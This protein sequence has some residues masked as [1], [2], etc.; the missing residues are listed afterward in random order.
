MTENYIS[1]SKRIKDIQIFLKKLENEN[2][3]KFLPLLEGITD[4]G[5]SLSLGF[6][7]YA[8]KLYYMTGQ[9]DMLKSEEQRNWISYLQSFQKETLDNFENQFIDEVLY[10]SYKKFK[11]VDNIKDSAKILLNKTNHF[12]FTLKKQKFNEAINAET[13]QTVST[14]FQVGSKNLQTISNPYN[15]KEELINYLNK[16]NWSTPWTSGAQFASLCLYEATQDYKNEKILLNFISKLANKDTGSYYL[17]KPKSNREIINGA[18]KVLSGLDW[19]ESEIHYP[20]KLIDFCLD[21]DPMDEGCDIVDYIYV[22]YRCSQQSKYKKNEINKLLL[23]KVENIYRLYNKED[24]AFS[25]FKN[26][27]QT[28]YYGVQIS[29]GLNR[30][31]IHGTLLCV[32]ALIMILECNEMNDFKFKLIK[33]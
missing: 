31:D 20:E 9:W 11:P 18:M 27:S 6:S 28:Y 24:K 15:S 16:L 5:R 17:N 19:L 10:R 23:S 12:N 3:P 29:K 4:E 32:W 22:L 21:N 14:L 13:K 8:L 33:P 2:Y 7:N 25:Y 1:I 30:A 26:K